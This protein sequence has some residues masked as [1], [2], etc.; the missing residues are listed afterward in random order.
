MAYEGFDHAGWVQL[1]IAASKMHLTPAAKRS[2]KDGKGWGAAPAIL[3]PF[4]RQCFSIL[5]IMGCGIYNAPIAWSGVE[6]S[7][8]WLFVP[9]GREMATIDGEALT[10][11]VLLCHAAAIRLSINAHSP[12]YIGLLMHERSRRKDNDRWNSEHPTI[13]QA[14]DRFN[15]RFPVDHPIR[16]HEGT[17]ATKEAR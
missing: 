4:H 12:G 8:A 16:W 9:W 2:A 5:G 11:A 17:P 3:N 15:K 1:Q 7:T 6:W 14:L 10:Y 13:E